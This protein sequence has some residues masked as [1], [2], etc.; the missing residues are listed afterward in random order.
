MTSLPIVNCNERT[1]NNFAN[2]ATLC[3]RWSIWFKYRPSDN[4]TYRCSFQYRTVW[5]Y[6][7]AIWNKSNAHAHA[8]IS[9]FTVG[10]FFMYG[11]L[12][13]SFG[14]VLIRE[15]SYRY[16]TVDRSVDGLMLQ[17]ILSS[18]FLS[19]HKIHTLYASHL[20]IN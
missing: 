2:Q 11:F 10:W 17:M 20:P 16:I 3:Q 12:V 9:E 1:W 6:S 15:F 5:S 7:R 19:V 13:I 4:M 8:V 14:R 18:I